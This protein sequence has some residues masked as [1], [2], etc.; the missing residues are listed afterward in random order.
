MAKIV[1]L[2][3]DTKGRVVLWPVVRLGEKRK[4]KIGNNYVGILGKANAKT[5]LDLCKLLNNLIPSPS[6]KEVVVG[7]IESG[8][9]MCS[10][11]ALSRNTRFT[12][13]T[14]REYKTDN[15]PI[16]IVEERVNNREHK[17]YDLDVDDEVI[18]I[19]D[20]ITSGDGVIDAYRTFTD[21][22]IK[23]KTICCVAEN[24]SDNAREKI[25]QETGISLISLIKFK[26]F[27]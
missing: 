22:G 8:V 27:E 15:E 23:V 24:I 18:L 5:T 19:E 2:Q 12:Y 14:K 11:L 1:I 13:S 7:M 4:Y 21:M 26:L 17:F 10:F 9:I 25:Q 16:T 6:K 20:E 3:D